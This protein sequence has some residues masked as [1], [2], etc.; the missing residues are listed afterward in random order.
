MYK[1]ILLA[2]DGSEDAIRA[3]KKI[4]EMQKL[5]KCNVVAFYSVEHHMIPQFLPTGL[6][7]FNVRPYTIPAMDYA[8]L[9]AEYEAAGKVLLAETKKMFDAEGGK[10]ETRLILNKS[11]DNYIKTTVKE[12]KFDLVVLGCKGHHSKLKE[13]FLGTVAEYALNH[14][15]CDVLIVR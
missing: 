10:V 6:P 15:D 3:T 9:R 2:T 8:K 13:V 11:P 7:F 1:K 12:E 5:T 4:I 14:A